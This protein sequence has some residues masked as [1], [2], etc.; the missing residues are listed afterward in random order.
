[1][2]SIRYSVRIKILKEGSDISFFGTGVAELL[3]LVDE[4]HS[5][6]K[7]CE[8]MQ[9]A[10]SK[11]WKIIKIAESKLGF[12][13]LESKAGGAYGGGSEITEVGKDFALSFL[14]FRKELYESGDILF[15]KH[16]NDYL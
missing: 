10:Y 1:M 3:L 4:T 16:F 7:A 13:L 8:Q 5:L 14:N 11:G 12:P 2:D 9:M 15:K 6:H